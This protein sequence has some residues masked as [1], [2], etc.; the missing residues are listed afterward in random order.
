MS[1]GG[2][3]GLIMNLMRNCVFQQRQRICYAYISLCW[4]DHSPFILKISLHHRIGSRDVEEEGGWERPIHHYI[5]HFVAQV[6]EGESA[7]SKWDPTVAPWYFT[8]YSSDFLLVSALWQR[9][10]YGVSS[11][12]WLQTT[13]KLFRGCNTQ[14]LFLW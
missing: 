4:K 6:G 12:F 9:C 11:S 7:L 13:H 8:D 1:T 5:Y 14:L 2:C 10:A 3:S